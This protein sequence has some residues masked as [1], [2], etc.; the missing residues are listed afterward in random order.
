MGNSQLPLNCRK[1]KITSPAPT[2]CQPP[3]GAAV[4]GG[5]VPVRSNKR[6]LGCPGLRF[7]C[8][9]GWVPAGTGSGSVVSRPRARADADT[10]RAVS[11]GPGHRAW[12]LCSNQAA[13]SP[14]P[15]APQQCTHGSSLARE[16]P[17]KQ[18]V[19]PVKCLIRGSLQKSRWLI[20][21]HEQGY[22]YHSL[23]FQVAH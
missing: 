5:S 15:S 22:I 1:F 14:G 3:S 23:Q 16:S 4:T 12:L 17:R 7:G 13:G 2:S 18:R 8:L 20:P 19:Q 10:G 6:C 9:E 21:R 11:T